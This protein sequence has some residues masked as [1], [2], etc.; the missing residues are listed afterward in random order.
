MY[1]KIILYKEISEFAY[2]F[3]SLSEINPR[4]H[5][6]MTQIDP[7]RH[8]HKGVKFSKAHEFRCKFWNLSYLY[9]FTLQ[10]LFYIL[11]TL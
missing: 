2:E 1:I 6:S 7:T 11:F 4:I 8:C 10:Q 3:M 9:I 5:I